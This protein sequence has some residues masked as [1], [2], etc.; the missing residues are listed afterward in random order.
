MLFQHSSDQLRDL[1]AQAL[2]LA[3][4]FGATAAE[5]NLSESVGQNVQVRLQQLEQ[6][7]HC[8]DKSLDVTV[9]A[10]CRKG[11]ASTADLSPAAIESTVRAALDIARYT[12]E[13]DCAGLADAGQ[14]ASDCFDLDQ[15]HPWTLDGAAAAALA[16]QCEAAALAHD[17][18]VVNSEGATVQTGHFHYVYGNSHGF[19]QYRRGT[20]HSLSCSVVAADGNGNMERDYWYETGCAAEDLGDAAHI[21]RTAAQRAAA[22]LGAR[23]VATGNYPV[24]FDRTVSPTLVGHL[25]G[26]LSGGALYRKNSFLCDSLGK[27]ILPEY[28]SLREEPHLP[29][30]LGSTCFDAEGVATRPRFVIENGVVRGYF[31]GSY[32]ARKLGM[33]TTGNAGGAHNLH[34]NATCAHQSDLL[35][36]MGC[37]LLITELMG[38]GANLLTG[39][40]SRGAAGFWVENGEIAHPVSGITIAGRLPDMLMNIT[41]AADDAL[42]RTSGKTGSLLISEMTVAGA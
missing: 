16:Q 19:L 6:I 23:S 15:Y 12:A 1:A 26:A 10:G 18:R 20:R 40:Y 36:Q 7:E 9:Y 32:S 24:L 21:G 5:A 27:Q 4:R 41:A 13:D 11:C 17:K 33:T 25:A 34:L 35:Q 3:K 29:R 2:D 38:Q 30:R 42:R 8:E 14:M 28:L 31:L 39:D 22:R 37:G